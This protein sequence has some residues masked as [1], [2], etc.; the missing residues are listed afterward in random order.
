MAVLPTR[1]DR[2]SKE[3]AANAQAMEALLADFDARLAQIRLGGG[4]SARI[5]SRGAD[6]GAT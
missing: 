4:E 2:S 5:S 1:I 6:R 3:Y